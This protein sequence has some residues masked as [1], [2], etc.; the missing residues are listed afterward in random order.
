MG[1]VPMVNSH[2][3]AVAKLHRLSIQTGLTAWLGQAFCER[4]YEALARTP[5]SFVLVHVDDEGGVLGFVCGATDTSKAHRD[6][7]KWS[8]IPLAFSAIGKLI[9]PSVWKKIWTALR[10]PAQF[11][12]NEANAAELPVAELVSIGVDPAAQGKRIGTQLVDALFERFRQEGVSRCLVWTSDD[13]TAAQAF[14][15]RQGFTRAGV[16][17]H[18]SGPIHVFVADFSESNALSTDRGA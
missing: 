12:E 3:P 4:Y 11:Q 8:L 7:L 6:I 10:R 18:H 5:H 17:A 1:I 13:N 2:A 9:R 14:Y 15:E 16:R